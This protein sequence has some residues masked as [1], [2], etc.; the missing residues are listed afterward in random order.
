MIKRE[1]KDGDW[2]LKWY[3]IIGQGEFEKHL[4]VLEKHYCYDRGF[5]S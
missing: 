5:D 1:T 4:G 3:R 2:I